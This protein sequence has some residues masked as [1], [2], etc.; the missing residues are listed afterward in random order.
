M[1]NKNSRIKFS[2]LFSAVM[3][4]AATV[5][6]PA[7]ADNAVKLKMLVITT[8]DITQDLGF[9]YIKPVLDEMGVPYDVLNAETQD[10][11]AAMLASSSAGAGC[12]AAE[13][14]L[15]RQL[16]R[17][18]PDRFRPCR[19]PYASGMG[20]AAQLPEKLQCP[21]RR[22]CQDG[23]PHIGTRSLLLESTWIMVWSIRP[24]EPPT[25]AK[26]TVPTRTTQGSF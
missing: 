4:L 9:A 13:A 14:G 12:M 10:L 20:H 8:G 17:H 3:W 15:R 18:H 2:L 7:F 21:R 25:M 5:T 1:K 24:A 22:C 11:T 6:T 16:Q 19:Q 23:R 26:W